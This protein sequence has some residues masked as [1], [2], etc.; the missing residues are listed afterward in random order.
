MLGALDIGHGVIKED[1]RCGA[2]GAHVGWD[3]RGVHRGGEGG[4][5]VLGVELARSFVDNDREEVV[6]R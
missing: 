6:N 3:A 4:G 1:A 2:G 5:A